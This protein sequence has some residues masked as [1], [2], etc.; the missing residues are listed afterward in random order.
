MNLSVVLPAAIEGTLVGQLAIKRGLKPSAVVSN[1]RIIHELRTDLAL[2][3]VSCAGLSE[4]HLDA[5]VSV[6]STEEAVTTLSASFSKLLWESLG[7]PEHGGGEPPQHYIEATQ[8]LWFAFLSAINPR[9][10]L[11]MQAMQK[12][13]D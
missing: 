4:A 12:A 6:L 10:L 8:L 11:A 5:L 9:F 3:G 1:E 7:D 13:T 2:M